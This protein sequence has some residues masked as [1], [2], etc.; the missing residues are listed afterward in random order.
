MHFVAAGVI[1][2]AVLV[3]AAGAGVV[4]VVVVA[5]GVVVVVDGV[6]V[7]VVVLVFNVVVVFVVSLTSLLLESG[8]QQPD[9]DRC[10][11]LLHLQPE[12]KKKIKTTNEQDSD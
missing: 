2:G 9:W 5:A 7:M 8:P 6:V 4:V 12:K 1:A 3:V 11:A 10:R